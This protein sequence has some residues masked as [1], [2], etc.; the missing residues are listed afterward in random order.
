MCS[1][2]SRL[3]LDFAVQWRVEEKLRRNVSDGAVG[4]REGIIGRVEE[5]QLAHMNSLQR[6]ETASIQ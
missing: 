4:R 6:K 3:A 2:S 1:A 5:R